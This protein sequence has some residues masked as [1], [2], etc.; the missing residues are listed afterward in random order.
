MDPEAGAWRERAGRWLARRVELEGAG[1]V[2]VWRVD[3]RQ[4][5]AWAAEAA[6]LLLAPDEACGP[7]RESPEAGRRRRVARV[8]LRIALSRRLGCPPGSLRLVRG[9]RGKPALAGGDGLHFN[10]TRSGDRCLIALTAIGPVGIDV[11]RVARFPELEAITRNRFAP[12]EAAAI[13]RLHGERRVRAFYN[14]W[15]RKEAYLKATGAGLSN[16]LG[17]VTVTV[18]DAQPSVLSAEDGDS[19]SWALASIRTEPDLAGAVVV[20]GPSGLLGGVLTP[21]PLPLDLRLDVAA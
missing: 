10:L 17:A 3:L 20:R 2:S 14:C 5:A 1:G 19:R 16:G 7:E 15:T 8:A 21:Q 18:D 13:L 4:P 11:E 6:A 12:S 9:P